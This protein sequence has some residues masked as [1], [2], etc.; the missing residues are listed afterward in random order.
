MLM[1][2][3][4]SGSTGLPLSQKSPLSSIAIYLHIPFCRHKCPYCN[5]YV[6]P[7]EE[8][9]ATP[10]LVALEQELQL[11]SPW[12]RGAV[13][14]T[15]YL[16]GG[17]PTAMGADWLSTLLDKIYPL[18]PLSSDCEITVEA[19]PEDLDLAFAK[20]LVKSGVNRVSLGLQSS[21]EAL[22][23]LLGRRHTARRA[24]DA[25]YS[26]AEAGIERLSVDL[27]Y[28]LPSQSHGSWESTL[29]KVVEL[30]IDHL[31]LYELTIEPHT[32]F[33]KKRQQLAGELPSQEEGA[34]MYRVARQ[35]LEQ[36]GFSQYEVASFARSHSSRSRHNIGYWTGRSFLGCGPS[37]H[38]YWDG[39]RFANW[40]HFH[41]WQRAITAQDLA[42]ALQFEEELPPLARRAELLA[43]GLRFLEGIDLDSFVDRWGAID[44]ELQSTIDQLT[45]AGLL[46]IEKG[47]L[48][49][50]E[51]GLFV[52]DAVAVELIRLPA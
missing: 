51:R 12:L 21:E 9:F 8:R 5:F 3:S 13:V 38:S 44:E 46:S 39:R 30:P 35:R 42:G 14:D 49:L 28:Q 34:E 19:N 23:P 24:F 1:T 41:K 20:R 7:A 47:R 26:C 32:S 29:A 11:R 33:Y 16:G 36:Q 2:G 31:S 17:T 52:Y 6:I 22:L 43:V 45:S 50:T 15:L 25:I 18:L 40:A 27:M 48:R 37:A 10:Y 4:R